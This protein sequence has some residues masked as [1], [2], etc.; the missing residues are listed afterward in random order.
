MKNVLKRR[1]WCIATAKQATRSYIAR[2]CRRLFSTWGKISHG[3]GPAVLRIRAETSLH[4]G[5]GVR[6]PAHTGAGTRTPKRSGSFANM[7]AIFCVAFRIKLWRTSRRRGVC[8]RDT[9][10]RHRTGM[11]RRKCP[12]P[13]RLARRLATVFFRGGCQCCLPA[14][15]G[16]CS[17]TRSSPSPA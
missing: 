14:C 9:L 8:A 3:G 7:P 5:R 15:A 10:A 11:R 2:L 1:R 6:I 13:A 12:D 17:V 4:R 16:R